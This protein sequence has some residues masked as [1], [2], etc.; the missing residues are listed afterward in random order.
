MYIRVWLKLQ[1]KNHDPLNTSELLRLVWP[2]PV[3]S[4]IC[5]WKGSGYHSFSCILLLHHSWILRLI[6]IDHHWST[7]P[8]CGGGSNIIEISGPKSQEPAEGS[9]RQQH[10]KEYLQ[11]ATSRGRHHVPHGSSKAWNPE[12][13]RI[14]HNT[15]GWS[16]VDL[17]PKIVLYP[18]RLDTPFPREGLLLSFQTAS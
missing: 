14:E 1:Q 7:V 12:N 15:W 11:P 2:L 18:K 8:I 13:P 10:L 3:C 9:R 17:G 4:C 6:Y 5:G 16:G